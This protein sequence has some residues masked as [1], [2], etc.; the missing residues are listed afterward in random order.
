MNR[1]WYTLLISVLLLFQGFS[2]FSQSEKGRLN[3]QKINLFLRVKSDSIFPFLETI[4]AQ[5]IQKRDTNLIV[6]VY[7]WQLKAMDKID[8][9]NYFGRI[10]QQI[11]PQILGKTSIQQKI[12]I[13]RLIGRLHWRSRN[14]IQA[15][16]T[17]YQLL[18][19]A[20]AQNDTATLIVSLNNLGL[21]FGEQG[22]LDSALSMHQQ[23]LELGRSKADFQSMAETLNLMG[24]ACLRLNKYAQAREFYQEAIAVAKANNHSETMA[25]L[26]LNLAKNSQ[27]EGK[28]ELALQYLD[29]SQ[30]MWENLNNQAQLADLFVEKGSVYRV[31]NQYL[32]SLEN[33]HKALEIRKKLA[34]RMAIASILN[35]IGTIYKE[36]N[37]PEAALKNYQQALSIYQQLKNDF[38]VAT[39]LNY[40]GGVYYKTNRFDHALDYYLSSLG[41]FELMDDKIEMAKVLI[42]VALMYKNLGNFEKSIDYYDQALIIYRSVNDQKRTADVLSFIGNLYLIW[43]NIVKAAKNVKEALAIRKQINDTQGIISSNYDLA[44]I[45]LAR[46]DYNR[47]EILLHTLLK[48]YKGLLNPEFRLQ[49]IQHLTDIYE[50]TGRYREAYSLAKWQAALQDSLMSREMVQKIAEFKNQTDA[51]NFQKLMFSDQ[52]DYQN[53]NQHSFE[54]SSGEGNQNKKKSGGIIGIIHVF[55]LLVIILVVLAFYN[56]RQQ[57]LQQ[58][59]ESLTNSLIGSK[60]IKGPS[61]ELTPEQLYLAAVHLHKNSFLELL[62]ETEI[63]LLNADGDHSFFKILAD[64][65]RSF[66]SIYEMQEEFFAQKL[67]QNKLENEIFVLRRNVEDVKRIFSILSLAKN[68]TIQNLVDENVVFLGNY[69]YLSLLLGNL[70]DFMVNEIQGGAIISIGYFKENKIHHITISCDNL[71]ISQTVLNLMGEEISIVDGWQDMDSSSSSL[72]VFMFLIQSFLV[73]TRFEKLNQTG[74]KIILA[75]PDLLE[76]K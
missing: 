29:S 22:I 10:L 56:R 30:N 65:L 8:R 71:L 76:K 43:G 67:V 45:A 72:K 37:M 59:Q 75:L 46:Q 34:D 33:Y 44:M 55:L 13:Q 17:F 66:I 14:F 50:K 74:S 52:E 1:F 15:K 39:T 12:E 20:R 4:L 58:N 42:N 62:R 31:S 9:L 48:S 16:Q 57:R 6:E 18:S 54:P 53:Y 41:H 3:T 23:A 27:R 73:T 40:I 21:V 51:E 26:W 19:L 47:A 7:L 35:N 69:T 49:I 2:S 60:N 64:H 28:I 5:A 68:I 61:F 32:K 38:F 70:I 24:N 36:L 63:K 25:K 11:D